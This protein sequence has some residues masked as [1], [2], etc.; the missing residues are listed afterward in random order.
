M[1]HN[2]LLILY[3]PI[4]A[5]LPAL[6]CWYV[7]RNLFASARS[8]Y[9]ALLS[10]ASMFLVG[11][12]ACL[13]LVFWNDQ[14]RAPIRGLVTY[15]FTALAVLLTTAALLVLRDAACLLLSL[16]DRLRA[17]KRRSG[18]RTRVRMVSSWALLVLALG[19][20]IEG[21]AIAAR[22]PAVRHVKVAIRHLPQAFV[23]FR[24][25]HLTDIHI[26]GSVDRARIR[27]LVTQVNALNADLVAITGD[28]VDGALD[29]LRSDLAPLGALRAAHGVYAA[30]GNHEY[31]ADVD[32]CVDEFRRL[33][34]TVLLNEHAWVRKGSDALVVAGVTNP[35]RGMHGARYSA[36]RGKVA[37]LVSSPARALAGAPSDLPRILLAHQPR[38]VAEARELGV[39]LA[40]AGHTHG[41]QFFPWNFGAGLVYPYPTGL[42][43]DGSMQVYVGRGIG[44]FGPA[45]RLGAPPE[46]TVIELVRDSAPAR[47]AR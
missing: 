18:T 47:P 12:A 16:L 24:V 39:D 34:Q 36:S 8:R 6:L 3:L 40:L 37:S 2:Q 17:P 25:V 32:A 23:G 33:G 14:D 20:V 22:P 46:I 35:Q 4:T 38:S 26:H 41:G 42:S 15:G 31:Y 19:C 10:I 13:A 28:V 45:T 5:G 27:A 1:N 29:N 11:L 44:T 30:V 43:R 9:A 21:R 7:G